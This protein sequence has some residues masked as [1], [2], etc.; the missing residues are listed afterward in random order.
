MPDFSRIIRMAYLRILDREPDPG[1][2][3]SFNGQMNGGMSEAAMREALLRSPEFA[4]RNPDAGLPAR[5]GL[6][7]HIPSDPMIDDVTRGLGMRWVRLDFDWF[8]IEPQQGEFH[9]EE[10]DRVVSRTAKRGA[11]MLA[12]LAYTPPWASP[13]SGSARI[14]DPPADTRFWTDFVRAAIERYR[15]EVQH[16]QF[17]NEPNVRE[18]WTGSR[19]QYRTQILEPAASVARSIDPGL[20]VVAPGLANLR[21]WRD[22]FREAMTARDAIDVVDHHNYQR[23]GQEVLRGLERDQ[24]G[25][26]SLRTLMRQLA[27]DDKPFWLTETG[28]RSDQA[29][30]RQYYEDVVA[31]LSEKTWVNR[32]FFFHYWDGPGQGNGGLGIVNED[33]SPKPAYLFLQ[34]ILRPARAARSHRRAQPATTR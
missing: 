21:D 6:N 33:F 20:K 18:F 27:V 8:R 2:L 13:R 7:V 17:W 9:W 14:S 10:L 1:G 34:T 5:L 23:S 12:T 28:T 29:D 19:A 16:W 11:G 30:Q 4:S 24:P 26:P 15:H 25:Q 32:L 22:W 31:V 3:A